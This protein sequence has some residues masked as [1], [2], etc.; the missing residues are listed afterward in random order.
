[1]AKPAGNSV[2]RGAMIYVAL[3][4]TDRLIGIIST[5]VLA[6]LLAPDDFGIVAMTALAVGLIDVLLD[7]GV[8]VALI[9][10]PNPS[11]A[12][13]DTAWTLRLL[14][15]LASMLLLCL[16][17]PLAARYFH[18]PRVLPVLLVMST[19]AVIA[20]CENIGIV[21]FQKEMRADRD[22]VFTFARR[23]LGLV[24]TVV[25]AWV[26]RDYWA[27]V[28]GTL[29]SRLF[30]VF[31]SYR[32]HPMR[33]G[34]SLASFKA[35]FGVSQWNLINSVGRYLNNN[36]HKMIVGNR[37]DSTTI[38]GYTLAEEISAMPA[39]E[40]L[41]PIN[42]ILFPAFVR[43]RQDLAE[44]KRMFLLAQGVQC[45]IAIPASCGLALVAPE[46]VH[47]MLGEKWAFVVPFVQVLSLGSIVQA[48]TTCSGYVLLAQ[49]WN[50]AATLT[51]WIQVVLFGLGCFLLPAASPALDLAWLRVAVGA[52]GLLSALLMLRRCLPLV[53]WG[54]MLGTILR[55]LLA[56]AAMAAV[57]VQ[58][59]P[60]L[61]G[62]VLLALLVK[63]VL[64]ALVYG[65]VLLGLWLLL[66][67]PFGAETYL[68]EKVLRRTTGAPR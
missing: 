2:V 51:T 66:G 23:L 9:Q 10:N 52:A 30:G 35:I 65:A 5:V 8:N 41:S 18:E 60:W 34:F 48:I 31:L 56:A 36:L 22:F 1:M 27:L 61:A 28:W 25:L 63:V 6:R 39:T 38:G 49:S 47:L 11:K 32:M 12:D 68:L 53:G 26:L 16:I 13:Y 40:I 3:R 37:F 45:L 20:A 67:K 21:T 55:P 62:S 58:P 15:A 59:A 24:V 42:R 54:D 19:A 14:Q 46:V 57:L 17:A 4:W 64:G 43:A 29:V 33:C 50:R 7:L 44:L